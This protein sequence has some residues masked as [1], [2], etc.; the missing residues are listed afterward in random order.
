VSVSETGEAEAIL[1]TA[2]AKAE[3][4]QLVAK[5]LTKQVLVAI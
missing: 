4:I 3:A 1:A 5:A 2:N